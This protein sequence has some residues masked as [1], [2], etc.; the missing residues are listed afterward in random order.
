MEAYSYIQTEK[1]IYAKLHEAERQAAAKRYTAKEILQKLHL[2]T[3]RKPAGL[4][5]SW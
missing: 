4:P 1:E 2:S 5:F 3:P